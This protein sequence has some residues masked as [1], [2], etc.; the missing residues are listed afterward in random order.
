MAQATASKTN[1]KTNAKTGNAPKLSAALTKMFN[2]GF[3]VGESVRLTQRESDA[4]HEAYL[5]LKGD[6]KSQ[7]DMRHTFVAGCMASTLRITPDAAFALLEKSRPDAKGDGDKRTDAEQRAYKAAYKQFEFHVIRPEGVKNAG[8]K[9][10]RAKSVKVAK[11]KL[12][13]EDSKQCLAGVKAMGYGE[14]TKETVASAIAYLAAF[15]E[16]IE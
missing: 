5:A 7:Q 9:G 2:F 15:A 12:T 3:T 10:N 11:V 14:V 16:T 8:N 6:D 1:A 13:T 4:H